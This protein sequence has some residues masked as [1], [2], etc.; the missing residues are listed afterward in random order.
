MLPLFDGAVPPPL[1]FRILQQRWNFNAVRLPVSVTQWKRDGSPY[2]DR[3]A[4]AVSTANRES[5]VVI[6]TAV[7]DGATLPG[8]ASLDFWRAAGAVLQSDTRA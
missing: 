6:L 2:L 5:L 4:A 7:E 8:A 3:I 1:T